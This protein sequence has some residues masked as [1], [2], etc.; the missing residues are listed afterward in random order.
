M[1]LEESK[2]F[3][4]KKWFIIWEAWMLD[5][6]HSNLPITLWWIW[7]AKLSL[8]GCWKGNS[9]GVQDGKPCKCPKW[10]WFILWG[11]SCAQYFPP[12][13]ALGFYGI[14]MLV[15]WLVK[16]HHFGLDWTIGWTFSYRHSCPQRMIPDD[17]GDHRLCLL[18]K[19][20]F[21]VKYLYNGWIVRHWVQICK[22]PT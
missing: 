9:R 15:G 4:E 19:S 5:H 21:W 8:E 16:D 14:A 11:V 2:L 3:I 17:L 7:C 18:G 1:G 20:S 6:S 13:Y 12:S 10:K 22:A